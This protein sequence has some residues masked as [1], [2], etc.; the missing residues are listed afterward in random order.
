MFKNLISSEGFTDWV[1]TNR[2]ECQSTYPIPKAQY[3]EPRQKKPVAVDIGANI[4]GFSVYNSDKFDKIYA[5]EPFYMNSRVM[6]HIL[7][8]LKISNVMVLN[9]AVHSESGRVLSLKAP[10]FE[11][12][13]DIEALQPD[14]KP[15]YKDTGQK[16]VTISLK[17]IFNVFSLEKIDYLKM[18]CEGAEYEI[19]ENFN[20][21]DKIDIMSLEIHGHVRDGAIEKKKKLIRKLISHYNLFFP[22]HHEYENGDKDH[23]WVEMKDASLDH[24]SP[25][26]ADKCFDRVANL[27]CIHRSNSDISFFQENIFLKNLVEKRNIKLGAIDVT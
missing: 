5:F 18:D 15:H 2:R 8:E 27:L 12:S 14:S 17:D 7:S 22:A 25:E 13:G 19:L 11:C 10:N 21:Y 16:C 20:D 3:T 24:M 1:Q 6:K 26:E 23:G 9:H 4:G